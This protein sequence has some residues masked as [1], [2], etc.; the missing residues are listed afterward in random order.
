MECPAC[1]AAVPEGSRFC[2]ACGHALRNRA[3]ERRVV[4]VVFADLVGYTGMSEGVDPEH[5]KNLVDRA[6]QRLVTDV[7]NHGGRV[8][9]IVG[10]QIMAIF[11]APTAHEDDA[12]RAVRAALQMQRTLTCY[13]EEVA[14]P[15]AMRVG[16][17]TGE[18]LVGT[19]RALGEYTAMGDTVNVASRLQTIA[20]AGQVLVGPSTYGE[21][22]A[23][24]E[25]EPLGALHVRGREETVEAYVAIATLGPPGHRPALSRSPLKGRDHELGILCASVDMAFRRR[26][27]HVLVLLGD[28][29]IG[30]TR[31]ADEVTRKA[32]TDHD[33]LVLQGRCVPYGEANLWWPIAEAVRQALGIGS[34]DTAEEAATKTRDGVAFGLDMAADDPR[35]VRAIDGLLYLLGLRASLQ[36]V[37]PARAREDAT[38]AFV[39]LL[40]VLAQKHPVALVLS[41]LHWADATV[42]DLLDRLAE[43]MRGLPFVAVGT[44]RTELQERWSPSAAGRNLVQ[45]HLDPLDRAASAELIEALLDGAAGADLI[46]AVLDRAGGNPFFLEELTSLVHQSSSSGDGAQLPG[47]LRSIVATR[48]D[49]LPSSERRLLEHAAVVGRLG[50]VESLQA[51]DEGGASDVRRSLDLLVA[52]DLVEVNGREWA[53]RSDLVREV[54]YE[55]LT[56]GERARHHA[57][58]GTFLATQSRERGRER[59]QLEAIA[60]HLGVAAELTR[61]LGAVEGVPVGILDDA[62]DAIAR[63]ADQA[64]RRETPALVARLS[65]RAMAL[66]PPGR[67]DLR[68]RFLVRRARARALMR[69]M[70]AARGDVAQ[71]L[72]EAEAAGDEWTAASALTVRGQIEQTEGALY[73]S[74][75]NLDEALTRWRRL[76]DL[77]GE[78][79]ALRL[80]GVTDMFLGRLDAAHEAIAD[81]LALFTELDDRRGQAWARWTMAWI[82]FTGGDTEKADHHIAGAI[83]LFEEVGDYGGLGWAYGLLA[84]VRLQQ[85]FRDEADRL[86]ELSL[87]EVDAESDRWARGMMLML[88]AST[89]LWQGMTEDSVRLA[90]EARAEFQ[91]IGDSTGELRA[92][93][94]LARAMIAAGRIAESDDLLRSARRIAERELDPGA[95]SLGSL[96]T[97]GTAIQLGDIAKATEVVRHEADDP[98]KQAGAGLDDQVFVGL[99]L[100]QLARHEEAVT[101]LRRAWEGATGPGLRSNAG[102]ALA[103]ALAVA[104]RFDEAL[105]QADRS[106]DEAQ[107]GGTYLD[108]IA[109]RYARGF[110]SLRRDADL[111]AAQFDAA[112]TIADTTGDRL[113]QALARLA[114]GRA[115]ESRWHPRAGPSIQDAE[116]RLAAIGLHDTAWDDV[117]RRAARAG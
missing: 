50:T 41:E 81:A 8:D 87:R 12:E 74:V 77:A 63:A 5:V 35:A 61:D 59:E 90:T 43:R 60:H 68:R 96:I 52:S 76:G 39:G 17:N 109:I 24:V 28:A 82:A 27:P 11:G 42:L 98:G 30:K 86:A 29:G 10:D 117:F 34:S 97:L 101:V 113:T 14:V 116:A 22:S 18:A 71:A 66:L 114:R 23:S 69:Q 84:W 15:I 1:R 67:E 88:R 80:R 107:A 13:A 103:L 94:T 62:V 54:A 102:S 57:R 95:K 55:T 100:L 89:R 72:S 112:V 25:Y 33:A 2:P 51:V 48:I 93:A 46:E 104:G 85:G 40:Q 6:F 21:T 73:E 32:R 20:Q 37:E 78:A 36:D 45:L 91:A 16:I 83:E 75:A 7:V 47:S 44:G 3:E 115:L 31:L 38:R 64:E 99:A 65:D 56:K 26:R 79:E 70:D 108:R 9:K 105:E 92:T 106:E 19:L 58:L 4:T 110:A 111:A 49:H 53:F